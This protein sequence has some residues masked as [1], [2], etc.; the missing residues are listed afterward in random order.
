MFHD[1]NVA[2]V[3]YW[4][5]IC[6]LIPQLQYVE[7]LCGNGLMRRTSVEMSLTAKQ[8]NCF[9][10]PFVCIMI[11][12]S[13]LMQQSCCVIFASWLSWHSNSRAAL[14]FWYVCQCVLRCYSRCF[15]K[16]GVC[17]S[18]GDR[19]KEGYHPSSPCM[20]CAYV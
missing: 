10:P 13:C 6:S 11:P 20:V 5:K 19:G 1:S 7:S 15:V 14:S 17:K 2:D 18:A 12:Q 4:S 3:V 16:E 8:G 9:S